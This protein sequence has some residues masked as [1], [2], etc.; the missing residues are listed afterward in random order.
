MVAD[1]EGLIVMAASA[2][3]LKRAAE[4]FMKYQRQTADR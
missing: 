1:A 4:R 3:L 2:G